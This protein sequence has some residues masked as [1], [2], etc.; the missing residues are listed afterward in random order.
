MSHYDYQMGLE[1]SAKDYPFY[2]IVQAAI[3]QADSVN[4][5]K[6]RQAFPQV[7]EELQARYNAPGGV[8]PS[9]EIEDL[10]IRISEVPAPGHKGDW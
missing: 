4:L 7:W 6:L 9:D 2:A 1:I 3:R 5:E 10:H 8:L